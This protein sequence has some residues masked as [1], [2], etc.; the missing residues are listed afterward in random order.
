[1]GRKAKVLDYKGITQEA[2]ISIT[3]GG[4]NRRDI[5]PIEIFRVANERHP[6]F[7]QN[8]LKRDEVKNELENYKKRNAKLGFGVSG[9]SKS[10]LNIAELNAEDFYEKNKD[11]ILSAIK[12]LAKEYNNLI[13]Y[14]FLL[15][16]RY[17]D[18]KKI[19]SENRICSEFQTKYEQLEEDFEK[20]KNDNIKILKKYEEIER[21]L[22][23]IN[24][25]AAYMLIEKSFAENLEYKKYGPISDIAKELVDFDFDKE[26]EEFQRGLLTLVEKPDG[27]K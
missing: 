2:I 10:G 22:S 26:E 11:D 6:E 1:M 3:C 14:Y 5:K 4:I 25:T 18:C 9:S 19:I 23:E 13:R 20:V 24:Q 15:N 16:I 17:E 7:T 21:V 8:D 27:K 12:E